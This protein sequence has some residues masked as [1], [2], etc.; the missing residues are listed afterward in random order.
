VA[1]ARAVPDALCNREVYDLEGQ[2]L[3]IPD[4]LD[5]EAGLIGE[6]QGEDHKDGPQHRKDAPASSGTATT[7][8]STSSSWVAT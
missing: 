8:S 7:A 2:L 1:R 5:V 4:L 3:G 6:Y